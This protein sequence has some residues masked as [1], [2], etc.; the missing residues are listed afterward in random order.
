[1]VVGVMFINSLDTL[2]SRQSTRT[3][4]SVPE[5]AIRRQYNSVAYPLLGEFDEIVVV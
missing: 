1:V 2:V 3:D 5:D 4:K